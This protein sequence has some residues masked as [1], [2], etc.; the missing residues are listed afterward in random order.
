MRRFD[1]AWC[2]RDGAEGAAEGAAGFQRRSSLTAESRRRLWTFCGIPIELEELLRP[3]DSVGGQLWA[4]AVLLASYLAHRFVGPESL[5]DVVASTPPGPARVEAL[6]GASS[7]AG[8]PVL[9][10]GSGAGLTSIA[11]GLLGARV[12]ATDLPDVCP[13]L[14]RNLSAASSWL[15]ALAA[16]RPTVAPLDW[17]ALEG[18]GAAAGPAPELILC[19]DV[20]YDPAAAEPLA[21]A[22]D[23][24]CPEGC[25]AVVAMQ[26][27]EGEVLHRFLE[28]AE[29]RGFAYER[30]PDAKLRE[31]APS[32]L[33]L[34]P[35]E[36]VFLL[37]RR[38]A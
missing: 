20:I 12:R 8:R 37:R 25:E 38:A 3:T 22:L 27:R 6:R 10:L 33:P 32:W 29:R 30:L 19:A 1:C 5:A 21:A 31:F 2:A 9:E 16:A 14:E 18:A 11:A 13:L 36:G 7:L 23:A 28:R 4:G 35:D 24:L 17:A 26:R 15:P 34:A